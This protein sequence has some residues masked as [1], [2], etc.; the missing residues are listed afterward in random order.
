MILNVVSCRKQTYAGFADPAA[1]VAY[2]VSVNWGR[3]GGSRL[4]FQFLSSLLTLHR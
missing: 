1:V 4:A 2:V 3:W